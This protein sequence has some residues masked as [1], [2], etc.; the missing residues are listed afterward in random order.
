MDQVF[1]SRLLHV[2][3]DP[4]RRA[5]LHSLKEAD[6]TVTELAAPLRMTFPAASKHVK[7]L[8]EAGLVSRQVVGRKHIVHATPGPLLIVDAWLRSYLAS[9]D[10]YRCSEGRDMIHDFLVSVDSP[11]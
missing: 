10:D 2:L 9:H 3:S 7:I 8:E 11:C 4:T 1:L 5:M 6:K